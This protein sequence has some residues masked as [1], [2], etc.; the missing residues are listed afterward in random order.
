MGVLAAVIG[1]GA[2]LIG[3]IMTNK[4]NE[5]LANNANQLTQEQFNRSLEFNAA[6][7]ATARAF[8]SHEAGIARSFNSAEAAANRAFNAA[9]A[10]KTRSWMK[11]MSSTVHQREVKDLKK[12]G[13]NPILSAH[14]GANVGASPSASGSAASAA[15][16]SGVAASASGQGSFHAPVMQN[17]MGDAVSTAM[18]TLTGLQEIDESDSRIQQIASNIENILEDTKLKGTQQEKL[19]EELT[20][21]KAQAYKNAAEA[22]LADTKQFGESLR[23]MEEQAFQNWLKSA[24][25]RTVMYRMGVSKS[26]AVTIL[27]KVYNSLDYD[28][29]INGLE[30]SSGHPYAPYPR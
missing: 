3:G 4:K 7:A 12:A 24:Q 18:D 2:S 11:K 23:N 1:A 17:V 28:S 22:G 20:L 13:L 5:Q 9:E 15:A 6:E 19:V 25:A 30:E 26:A 21:V 14:G 29:L 10:Q 16:A 8:S 27:E